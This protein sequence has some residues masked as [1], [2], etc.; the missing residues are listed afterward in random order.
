MSET[1]G[2]ILALLIIF[3]G[4]AVMLVVGLKT[5]SKRD[6]RIKARPGDDVQIIRGFPINQQHEEVIQGALEHTIQEY[7]YMISGDNWLFV[8]HPAALK[9][10]AE[11]FRLFAPLTVFAVTIAEYTPTIAIRNRGARNFTV[12]TITEN[13]NGKKL[14]WCEGVFDAEQ[15]IFSTPDMRIDAL[16]VLSPEVLEVLQ[17]PPYGADIY[18]KRNQLYYFVASRRGAEEL[19]PAFREHAKKL[20]HELEANLQRWGRAPSNRD[21]QQQIVDTELSVTLREQWERQTTA[22]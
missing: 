1:L 13:I 3:G 6:G 2:I 12:R 11:D 15:R 4:L 9:A 19:V 21:K 7:D 18:L 5:Q 17:N 8:R 14:V 20:T 10:P 22:R 16:S